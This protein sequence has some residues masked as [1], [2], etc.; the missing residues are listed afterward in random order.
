MRS[1][2]H[3]AEAEAAGVIV[4]TAFGNLSESEDFLRGLFA[5]GPGLVNPLTFP[6][7]VLNAPAGYV[8]IDLGLHGPNLTVVRGE[9]SGEAALALA[10]DTITSGHA[11]VLLAG[12]GDE[13]SPALR[14][15]YTDLRLLSPNDGGEEWSSPFDPR[16]N[17][18]VMGEGAAILVL[19]SARHATAR[20]ARVLAELVGH[21]SEPRREPARLADGGGG[22][23]RRDDPTWLAAL[24]S[25]QRAERSRSRAPTRP[26]AATAPTPL[27]SRPSANPAGTLVT[28]LKGAGRGRARQRSGRPRPRARRAPRLAELGA[29][30]ADCTLSLAGPRATPPR[31]GFAHALV[32]ATRGGGCLT[33]L[34]R[35]A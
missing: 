14:Q 15:I 10:C 20:G 27:A 33:L 30:D 1:R 7:L 16:R 12:G 5:K 35:R 28:S 31:H 11:E 34:F 25:T 2:S 22:R 32:S 24:G 19:E 23:P 6:N 13:L 3:G 21:A 26:S 4:G 18:F 9:A 29:P 8:A 17:G